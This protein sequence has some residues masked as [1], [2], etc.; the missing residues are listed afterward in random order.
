M[1]PIGWDELSKGQTYLAVCLEGVKQTLIVH[2][3]G[4]I[5]PELGVIPQHNPAERKMAS[6][7]MSW[8]FYAIDLPP[9][10]KVL[11]RN[12]KQDGA[13]FIMHPNGLQQHKDGHPSCICDVAHGHVV[14]FGDGPSKPLSDY[15]EFWFIHIPYP[16][17][18]AWA[19]NY[20]GEPR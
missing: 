7:Y 8:D 15:A 12:L 13:Y 11:G 1:I 3:I 6:D 14:F 20:V 10:R 18:K 2:T 16:S 17:H 4:G 9:P 5:G 19:T